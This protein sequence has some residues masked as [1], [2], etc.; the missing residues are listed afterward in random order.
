MNAPNNTQDADGGILSSDLF[1]GFGREWNPKDVVMTPPQIAKRIVQHF[2]P[3]GRILDP[4]RGNGAFA[5]EMPGCEWCEIREGKDF[6]EWHEPVDWIVSNPPYSNFYEWMCHSFD[7]A[8]NVVYL[9][10]TQK[11]FTPLRCLT[12]ALEYGGIKEILIIGTGT[13]CGFPL[14]FAVGA[15][16]FKRGYKGETRIGYPPNTK[17]DSRPPTKD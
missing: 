14:G 3:S 6:M 1:G 17:G 13:Q 5:D 11:V 2:K 8:E 7:V 15:V 9:I 10:P 4:C 12:A 16:H